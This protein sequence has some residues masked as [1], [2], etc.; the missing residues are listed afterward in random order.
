M[1]QRVIADEFLSAFDFD[2]E[3]MGPRAAVQNL[4]E[5]SGYM[6]MWSESKDADAPDRLSN[7]R[8]LITNVISKYDNLNDFLEQASLMMTDD[9]D[10]DIGDLENNSVKIMTIH[11]A[12]GLEFNTVFL[13]AWEEGVFPNEK[14]INDGGIEEERRLAYVAL[15]RAQ[16]SAIITNA[17]SRFVYGTRQYNSPSRFISEMDSSFLEFSGNHQ[18]YGTVKKTETISK[19]T[20][21]VIGKLVSHNDLG[22]GVVI[23]DFG[24]ILTIAFKGHGIKKVAREFVR[25][26]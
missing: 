5:R 26:I 13:P 21:T 8:E 2:W 14:S 12:K 23:E 1:K 25:I 4:L 16:K 17:M 19:N 15:T 24:G 6:K 7:L 20:E 11:A 22:T 10:S 3:N 18:N 9:N